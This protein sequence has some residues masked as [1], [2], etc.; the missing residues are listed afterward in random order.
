M[1][2]IDNVDPDFTEQLELLVQDGRLDEGTPAYG[3]ARQIIERG[4]NTLT[5]KQATVFHQH[6]MPLIDESENE[7]AMQNAM[8]KERD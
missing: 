8:A 6:I 2:G 5:D 1:S 3:I 7:Q 4:F